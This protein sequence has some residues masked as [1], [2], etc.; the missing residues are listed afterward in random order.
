MEPTCTA[1]FS[2]QSSGRTAASP[3]ESARLAILPTNHQLIPKLSEINGVDSDCT[4]TTWDD[5]I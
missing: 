2:S 5:A 3:N 1:A 4:P